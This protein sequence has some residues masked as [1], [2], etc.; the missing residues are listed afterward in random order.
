MTLGL[1]LPQ[2]ESMIKIFYKIFLLNSITLG[3]FAGP[4]LTKPVK[5]VIED[6]DSYLFTAIKRGNLNEIRNAIQACPNPN[7]ADTDGNNALIIAALR[8]KSNIVKLLLENYG[9]PNSVNAQGETP[10]MKVINISSFDDKL[11]IVIYLCESGANINILNNR[12][13]N[14]L[15]YL[16]TWRLKHTGQQDFNRYKH[17]KSIFDAVEKLQDTIDYEIV[18]E[19]K[20]GS[21]A[22]KAINSSL[23]LSPYFSPDFQMI[24]NY[25]LYKIQTERN[26][27]VIANT[28]RMLITVAH[29][30]AKPVMQKLNFLEQALN[31]KNNKLAKEI[32]KQ[33]PAFN[34]LPDDVKLEILYQILLKQNFPYTNFNTPIPMKDGRIIRFADL[35]AEEIRI[36]NM[37]D[38]SGEVCASP[39]S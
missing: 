24:L 20:S 38:N 9:N 27:E 28:R 5:P 29:R 4:V 36:I 1:N 16:N 3:L 14:A 35:I 11:D 23:S 6:P 7:F 2:T 13:E 8:G 33:I 37:T 26:P 34:D 39:A 17:L 12:G 30:I 25:L 31:T 10:L 21:E 32:T 15:N 18:S 22:L 19:L